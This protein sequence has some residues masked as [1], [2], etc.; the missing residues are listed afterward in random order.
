MAV[1]VQNDS[2][3]GDGQTVGFLSPAPGLS[4]TEVSGEFFGFPKDA[5]DAEAND[6]SFFRFPKSTTA[7]FEYYNGSGVLQWSVAHTNIDAAADH[8]FGF[9]RD[10]T[11]DRI[12]CAAGDISANSLFYAYIT[13]S[14]GA[15]TNVRTYTITGL[16]G[17]GR[18]C[19]LTD[20][21]LMLFNNR[22]IINLDGASTTVNYRNTYGTNFMPALLTYITADGLYGVDGIS[23]DSQTD[24]LQVA[25]IS[26]GFG[27]AADISLSRIALSRQNFDSS[28]FE[29]LMADAVAA[30]NSSVIFSYPVQ[31]GSYI[32]FVRYFVNDTNERLNK[33]PLNSKIVLR[34]DFDALIAA[35]AQEAGL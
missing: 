35:A 3:S 10:G 34:S 16:A 27:V 26:S 11:A 33:S 7:A 23:Y 9:Y 18:L 5:Y 31:M 4:L 32:Q 19:S 30:F 24:F 1:P 29:A 22:E 8:W 2:S 14:T 25:G 28:I 6:G 13:V 12:Y 15:V 17:G 20:G 21:S